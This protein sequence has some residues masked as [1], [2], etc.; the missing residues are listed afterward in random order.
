MLSAGFG[1]VTLPLPSTY[2][3]VSILS[4]ILDNQNKL[5][6]TFHKIPTFEEVKFESASTL[7]QL[8][9]KQVSWASLFSP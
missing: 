8:Y 5:S 7:A 1:T 2:Y 6:L 3:Y 4:T 9:E